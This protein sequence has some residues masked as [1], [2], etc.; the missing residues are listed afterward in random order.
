[1]ATAKRKPAKK[2]ADDYTRMNRAIDKAKAQTPENIMKYDTFE[3]RLADEMGSE[4]GKRYD[5]ESG[6]I[7]NPDRS[8]RVPRKSPTKRKK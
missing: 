4:F 1:M 5:S 3:G 7:K 6:F 2:S 8:V